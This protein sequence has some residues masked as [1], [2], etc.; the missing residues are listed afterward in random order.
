RLSTRPSGISR[1]RLD[2]TTQ[3]AVYDAREKLEVIGT[4][5]QARYVREALAAGRHEGIL[6]LLLDLLQRLDAIRRE[7]RRDHGNPLLPLAGQRLDG[8]IGVGL[9]P[10]GPS[11]A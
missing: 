3:L 8:A 4:V 5:V 10:L 6:H 9:Q 2:P 7:P 11:E 1:A